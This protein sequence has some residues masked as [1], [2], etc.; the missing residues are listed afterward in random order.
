MD[1]N[2]MDQAL[3]EAQK[4]LRAGEVPVGA[5]VV[6]DDS[7]LGTGHNEVEKRGDATAHAEMLAIRR[8]C[9]VL[10]DWRLNGATIYVTLE[11]CHMC[12][13]AFYLSRVSR[14]VYGAAQPR[15][16]A[17]GSVDDFHRLNLFNH[18]IEVVA[19]VKKEKCLLLL[20]E[21]FHNLREKGK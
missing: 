15:S 21:F 12:M 6:R 18:E 13:G 4:A 8:A 7:L 16:G 1:E 10:G 5:V 17:C 3:A 9:S 11:P 14:V 20:R 19:G 2:W